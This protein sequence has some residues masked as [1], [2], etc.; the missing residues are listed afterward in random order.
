MC[1]EAI[2]RGGEVHPEP[3]RDMVGAEKAYENV[4]QVEWYD[5]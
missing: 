2:P 1:C 4:R 5:G 3:A